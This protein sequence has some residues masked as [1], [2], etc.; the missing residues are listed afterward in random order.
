MQDSYAHD[1]HYEDIEKFG[2]T[3]VKYLI[4]TGNLDESYHEVCDSFVHSVCDNIVG[5]KTVNLDEEVFTHIIN[6]TII[7]GILF[8]DLDKKITAESLAIFTTTWKELFFTDDLGDTIEEMQENLEVF[9]EGL[10][11]NK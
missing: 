3:V 8:H 10:H 4:G 5:T 9:M 6:G 11:S 1:I 2:R 7:A